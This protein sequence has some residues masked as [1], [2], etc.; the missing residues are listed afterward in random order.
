M[1]LVAA[2][3][4]VSPAE[5]TAHYEQVTKSDLFPRAFPNLRLLFFPFRFLC[6]WIRWKFRSQDA[7]APHAQTLVKDI[8]FGEAPRFRMASK[9]L[10]FSDMHGKQ[11]LKYSLSTRKTE[12]VYED[13]DDMVSGLGWLP[14]GRMLIVS[15]NMRRVVVY[16]EAISAIETYSDVQHVT[17]FRANDMVA[18]TSGRI[19]VGSFGFDMA[20]VAAF[21]SSAIVSVGVDGDVRVEARKMIFPNGM[22]ITPDGKTLIAAETFAGCL[23]AFDIEESGRLSNRRV[24][25]N[26][27]SLVDGICLDAEGCVWASICQSGVYPTGGGLLRVQEGGRIVDVLGFGANGIKESVFAC[28]LGTDAEG[29]HHLFFMEAVTSFDHLI[30]KRGKDAAKKNGLVR[31][32]EVSVGPARIPGNDNY[33]GGYC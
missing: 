12:L 29:K 22:V 8:V 26:V 17:R 2:E 6:Y 20:N 21:C 4:C 27:G 11:V 23:T 15:M 3:S 5:K 16:D 9:E 19:Y 25:A 18:S 31:S 10:V 33:C 30:F 1:P 14:D 7:A 32:I 13:P 28:Q 24:W